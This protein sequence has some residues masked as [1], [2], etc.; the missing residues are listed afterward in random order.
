M[1]PEIA[2]R[3]SHANALHSQQKAKS[4]PTMVYRMNS[5]G[6]ASFNLDDDQY[7]Q[8]M[9]INTS[10]SEKDPPSPHVNLNINLNR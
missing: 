6:S 8:I 7:Y 1:S 10:E 2:S 9:E 4:L 3:V 5:T